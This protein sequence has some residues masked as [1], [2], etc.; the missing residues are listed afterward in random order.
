MRQGRAIGPS[1]TFNL[2]RFSGARLSDNSLPPKLSD[3]CQQ[4]WL[5]VCHSKLCPFCGF[6]PMGEKPKIAEALTLQNENRIQIK[7]S[8]NLGN[9][10]K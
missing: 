7:E 3:C 6:H 9:N 10:N 5:S 4:I 2:M 8:L 1:D